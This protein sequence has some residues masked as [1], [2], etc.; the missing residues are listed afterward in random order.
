MDNYFV[1]KGTD[2]LFEFKG[3]IQIYNK[4]LTV[5]SERITKPVKKVQT[6]NNF[7][8]GNFEMQGI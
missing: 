4:T 1:S 6:Y 8:L 2:L 3:E 5:W 7:C